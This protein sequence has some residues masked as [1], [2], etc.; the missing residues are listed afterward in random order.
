MKK[1]A[2]CEKIFEDHAN[3]CTE[4]GAMLTY[5]QPQPMPV[6]TPVRKTAEKAI[7]A[8]GVT[9]GILIIISNL[10]YAIT[11]MSSFISS[12][13]RI[14]R[15]FSFSNAVFSLQPLVS[16]V[17]ILSS[18]IL[19]VLLIIYFKS[20]AES[21]SALTA[22]VYGYSPMGGKTYTAH[23]TI[24][25]IFGITELLQAVILSLNSILLLAMGGYGHP[26]TMQMI[27]ILVNGFFANFSIPLAT[28]IAV[29]LLSKNLLKKAR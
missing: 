6:Q 18:I 8:A 9:L 5:V 28:G 23:G 12:I 21:L 2:N 7:M 22:A 11:N 29:I 4:C 25:I 15:Y 26:G 24:G 14:P 17:S 16:I 10:I 20:P 13:T 27:S 1:C 3:H 19:G